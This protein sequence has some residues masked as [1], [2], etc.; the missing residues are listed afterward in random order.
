MQVEILS[1]QRVNNHGSFWQA[2]LL[3]KMLTDNGSEVEF[4]DIIPGRTLRSS[5]NVQKKKLTERMK[6]AFRK[7]VFNYRFQPRKTAI[8]ERQQCTQLLCTKEPNYSFDYDSI[9]IGRAEMLYHI[10]GSFS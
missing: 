8:F 6:H 10:R 4:I 2:Y 9:I 5:A 1:M 7:V 3:K